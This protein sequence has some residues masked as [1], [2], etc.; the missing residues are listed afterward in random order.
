MVRFPPNTSSLVAR[1]TPSLSLPSYLTPATDGNTGASLTRISNTSTGTTTQYRR[2]TYS[3]VQPWNA[4]GTQLLLGMCYGLMNGNTYVY[5]KDVSNNLPSWFIWSETNPLI[6]YG[7]A[8]GNIFQQFT[9]ASESKSTIYTVSGAS[10]LSFGE[11][12]GNF[13]I[14]GRYIALT[15]TISSHYWVYVYDMQAGSVAASFDLGTTQP[16]WVSMSPLG[17]YVVVNWKTDGTSRGQGVEVFNKTGTFQRQIYPNGE[18]GDL[19][20]SVAGDEVYVTMSEG[21]YASG[22]DMVRLSDGTRTTLWNTDIYACHVSTRNT[23]RPGWAYFSTYNTSNSDMPGYDE[24][25]ALKLDGSGT[26]ERFGHIH[27]ANTGTY[28]FQAQAVPN[29][30]GS[31]VLFASAWDGANGSSN[32]YAFVLEMLR[33]DSAG[34]PGP[35]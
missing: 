30:D 16:D 25:Y 12:E 2:H 29:R 7:T 26:A 33:E 19:G 24:V 14:D 5:S 3:K 17:T 4:D 15:P 32:V 8:S 10:A 6:G 22:I 18:H 21:A 1:A 31:R 27:H 11:G 13:S 23:K 9:M 35:F 34:P 28:E 20:I